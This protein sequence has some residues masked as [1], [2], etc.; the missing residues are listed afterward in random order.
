ML[1]RP[2]VVDMAMLSSR[3]SSSSVVGV[4]WRASRAG[5]ATSTGASSPR[6]LTT[7]LP[8]SSSV[9][10]TRSAT[11]TP[12]STRF[13]TRLLT[14]ISTRTSGCS[15]RKPGI[16]S[17]STVCASVTGQA[18]RKVP[19]GSLCTWATVSAAAWA[20]SRSAWQWRR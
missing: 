16:S 3:L 12:S 2:S 1:A 10:R 5:L 7:R 13:T 14:S 18:T 8:L 20:D 17:A 11:S 19:R 4:P 15:A 6:R 9:L